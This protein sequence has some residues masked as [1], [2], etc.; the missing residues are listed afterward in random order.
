MKVQIIISWLLFVF[1]FVSGKEYIFT[2][3][4]PQKNNAGLLRM[5]S[6]HTPV[7]STAPNTDEDKNAALHIEGEISEL[8]L[9]TANGCGISYFL[10]PASGDQNQG[11]PATLGTIEE[12]FPDYTYHILDTLPGTDIKGVAFYRPGNAPSTSTFFIDSSLPYIVVTD[13]GIITYELPVDFPG[14]NYSLEASDTLLIPGIKKMARPIKQLFGLTENP[15]V[16]LVSDSL[17]MHQL[18][19]FSYPDLQEQFSLPFH[20]VPELMEVIEEEIFL[21]GIDT[22]GDYTLYRFDVLQGNLIQSVVLNDLAMNAQEILIDGNSLQLLSSPGDSITMLSSLDLLTESLTQTVVYS[23]SGAR[24]TYNEYR[25]S[26]YFTFQPL[27]DQTG[28]FLN[29]QILIVDPITAQLDTFLVDMELDY[30]KHPMEVPQSFGFFEYQWFG[31][32]YANAG[33]DSLFIKTYSSLIRMETPGVPNYPNAAFTCFVSTQDL[34][35]EKIKFSCYPNPTSTKVTI[36]LTGL[37]KGRNYYL[38]VLDNLGRIHYSTELQAYQNI[39]LPVNRFAK[40]TYFLRLDTG[41]NIIS[42]KLIIN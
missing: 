18:R 33:Q 21:T 1:F 31:A 17:N 12:G 37:T 9:K 15:I 3:S 29:K 38:D 20:F 27:S 13:A 5:S 19:S 4:N 26:P 42:K 7:K 8:T 6:N 28:N 40:G 32:S 34:E 10:L 23:Q 25:N 39:Q 24:A 14:A 41:K 11:I 22:S 2:D 35:L 30:F 36:D 16:L